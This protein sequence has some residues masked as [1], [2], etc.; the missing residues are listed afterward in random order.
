MKIIKNSIVIVLFAIS[1]QACTQSS[2]A[3][4]N[5]N[6]LHADGVKVQYLQSIIDDKNPEWMY[7]ISPEGLYDLIIDPIMKLE[8][9][10]TYTDVPLGIKSRA[11]KTREDVRNEI[12]QNCEG[13]NCPKK[14]FHKLYFLEEWDFNSKEFHMSK[15]VIA[16]M[17]VRRF[18]RN[19]GEEVHQALFQI[20]QEKEKKPNNEL[21]KLGSNLKYEHNFDSKE[22]TDEVIGLDKIKFINYVFDGI[23]DKTIKPFEPTYLVDNTKTTFPSIKDLE[24]R[25]GESLDSKTLRSKVSSII[26]IEDWFVDNETL[27]ISKKVN[28]IGFVKSEYNWQTKQASKD[29]LFFVFFDR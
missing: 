4:E 28:G 25:C 6:A 14:E 12:L 5:D 2:P 18:L 3:V 27:Y 19:G 21:T 13:G 22:Y 9:D 26:F 1:M 15:N 24:E 11:N 20:I 16:Y 7:G 29:I 23:I 10:V 8:K 17:P